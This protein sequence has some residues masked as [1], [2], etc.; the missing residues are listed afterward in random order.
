LIVLVAVFGVAFLGER[1]TAS[2]WLGIVLIA[3]ARCSSPTRA[4]TRN[5]MY[6]GSHRAMN[7]AVRTSER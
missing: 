3:A 7:F 2:N 4:E 1:L 6:R 5:R